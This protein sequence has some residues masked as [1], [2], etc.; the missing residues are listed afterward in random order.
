MR[1][2]THCGLI[3]LSL[4]LCSTLLAEDAEA[5]DCKPKVKAKLEAD[6]KVDQAV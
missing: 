3:T 6:L 4:I 5:Q 1:T 2:L